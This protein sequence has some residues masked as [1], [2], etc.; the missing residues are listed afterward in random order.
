[1]WSISAAAF[2]SFG[3]FLGETERVAVRN[4]CLH[5]CIS[6]SVCF[7]FTPRQCACPAETEAPELRFTSRNGCSI[8]GSCRSV[9]FLE[10]GRIDIDVPRD[11]NAS[12]RTGTGPETSTPPVGV[13]RSDLGAGGERDGA[14]RPVVCGGSVSGGCLC[15]TDLS[16]HRRHRR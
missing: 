16:D 2:A 13:Q 11:R 10:R 5:T 7:R 4:A 1:M 9:E 8:S 14:G 3:S 15:R 12:F 6:R